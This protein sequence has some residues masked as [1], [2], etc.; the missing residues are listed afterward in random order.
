MEERSLKMKEISEQEWLDGYNRA[1]FLRK[2][3][4]SEIKRK[5]EEG[6]AQK[7][8]F[9]WLK[10][11]QDDLIRMLRFHGHNNDEM[12]LYAAY[13]A[14]FFST[15]GPATSPYIDLP[16]EQSIILF[17]ERTLEEMRSGGWFEK[18]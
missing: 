14:V 12:E 18:R 2:S 10:A 3:I 4:A 6:G 15:T 11:F 8:F 1:R 13:H 5:V 16:G 17:M 7:N 9:N